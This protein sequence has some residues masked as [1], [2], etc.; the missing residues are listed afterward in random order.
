MLRNLAVLAVLVLAV[1]ALQRPDP[2]DSAAPVG[3]SLEEWAEV[4]TREWALKS[5]KLAVQAIVQ[6]LTGS[7]L[8]ARAEPAAPVAPRKVIAKRVAPPRTL[9]SAAA[10]GTTWAVFSESVVQH[11]GHHVG[12]G[13]T[14]SITTFRM[15]IWRTTTTPPAPVHP[16]L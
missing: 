13:A 1:V 8:P 16:S 2:E 5:P 12:R 10:P 7:T 3:Q 4:F 9:R 11:S 14:V 15:V 6:P